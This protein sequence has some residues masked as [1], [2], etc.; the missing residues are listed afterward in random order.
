M[1]SDIKSPISNARV[2]RLLDGMAYV[3]RAFLDQFDS[4][5]KAIKYLEKRN[6]NVIGITVVE[7]EFEI[8]SFIEKGASK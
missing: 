8:R 3:N 7:N 4:I 2:F 1:T 6:W 5:D